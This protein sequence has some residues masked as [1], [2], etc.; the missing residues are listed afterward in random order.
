MKKLVA[1]AVV[2]A[3]VTG[4]VFAA[5]GVNINAWGRGAFA[6]LMIRGAPEDGKGKVLKAAN[7]KGKQTDQTAQLYT[8]VGN[9][10]GGGDIRVDFRIVGNSEYVGFGLNATAEQN[11][12]SGNDDAAYIWAKPFSSDVLKIKLGLFVEDELRGKIGTANNTFDNFVLPKK[13]ASGTVGDDKIF[14]DEPE[15]RIFSRFRT[16]MNDGDWSTWNGKTTGFLLTSAPIDG[17]FVG[18]LVVGG[19]IGAD[20]WPSWGTSSAMSAYDAYQ[21]MQVGAGYVI[22]NIGHVRAQYIGGAVGT[23]DAEKQFDITNKL[24]GSNGTFDPKQSGSIQ[25]AFALT[26]VDG[27][28]VD[29]GGR[30][31]LPVE[32]E[33][34]KNDLTKNSKT[35]YG[36]LAALGATFRKEA[37]SL[38]FRFDG[39]FGSYDRKWKKD[40]STNGGQLNFRLNPAFDLEPCT[41]GLVFGFDTDTPGTDTKGKELKSKNSKGKDVAFLPTTQLGFG[42][43]AQKG[44]GKGSIKAGLTFTTAPIK[45]GNAVAN[46]SPLFSIPVILEYAFF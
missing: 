32:D 41:V 8:G 13:V 30:F 2:F 39:R 15:D 35:S 20:Q 7:Y 36:T 46:T 40:D 34:L 5:D 43:Y 19:N 11:R 21:Y 28:L 31:W 44:L 25:A 16:F 14:L 4:V 10:W 3:L 23:Y 42:A 9:S 38:A 1:I 27:L 37:F 33:T 24:V 17:L 6:P 22:P 45:E 26:A 29:L 12:L 18:L